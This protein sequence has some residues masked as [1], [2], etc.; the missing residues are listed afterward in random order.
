MSIAISMLLGGVSAASISAGLTAPPTE[1]TSTLPFTNPG[2]EVD[3]SGWTNR[4]GV[5]RRQTAY[6]R[7]GVAAFAVGGQNEAWSTQEFTVPAGQQS[8]IDA[9]NRLVEVKHWQM[10]YDSDT[11]DGGTTLEFYDGSDALLVRRFYPREDFP[12]PDFVERTTSCP[13]PPGTRK[14]RWGMYGVRFAGIEISQYFDDI[15]PMEIKPISGKSASLLYWNNGNSRTGW[16]NVTGTL[17]SDTYD[18]WITS[19]PIFA[20]GNEA[21]AE[22]YIPLDVSSDATA[23]D[24][25]SA[26]VNLGVFQSSYNG[27][28]QGEIYL[29]F[30][31]GSGDL[32]GTQVTISAMATTDPQGTGRIGIETVPSGTRSIRLGFKGTR[33]DGSNLDAY[34]Q[35]ISVFLLTPL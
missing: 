11:D 6:Y 12:E 19:Q 28:D 31:D 13:I 15:G 17:I 9:G 18:T 21:T 8:P 33:V 2:A 10:G 34:F 1:T 3:V 25:G 5:L 23:I 30:R 20:W 27:N 29:E 14:I 4:R 16:V 7:T 26:E 35:W 22:A 32:I 24:T